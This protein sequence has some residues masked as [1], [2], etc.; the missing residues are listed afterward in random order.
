MHEQTIT[1]TAGALKQWEHLLENKPVKAKKSKPKNQS[2]K[3]SYHEQRRLAELPAEIEQLE[4]KIEARH[5]EAARPDFYQ[6]D[7]AIIKEY[8]TNTQNREA[9][10]AELYQ[11][12]EQLEDN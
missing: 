5:L 2:K 8:Q 10:L 3:L 1:Q 12:W 7:Q 6:K 11:L 4:A 9:K